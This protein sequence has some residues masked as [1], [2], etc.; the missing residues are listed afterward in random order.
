MAVPL[1]VTIKYFRANILMIQVLG[2]QL[3]WV[4]VMVKLSIKHF[5]IK[6]MT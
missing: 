1:M 6:N 4:M 2:L 3:N 5:M